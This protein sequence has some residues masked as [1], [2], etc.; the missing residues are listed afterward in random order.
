MAMA[1]ALRQDAVAGGA[2]D[3]KWR[4]AARRPPGQAGAGGACRRPGV[5]PPRPRRS[6][7]RN[8]RAGR[9]SRP[10]DGG[11]GALCGTRP[12]RAREIGM[13]VAT[14]RLIVRPSTARTAGAVLRARDEDGWESVQ[15]YNTESSFLIPSWRV[16]PVEG[17]TNRHTAAAM[18]MSDKRWNRSISVSYTH[19]RAHE[20]GRNL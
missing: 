3:R 13:D 19:L 11:A 8:P 7:R 10:G 12:G 1:C 14:R 6:S 18:A 9:A 15:T 20:T 5:D 2:A 17:R 4:G 16:A